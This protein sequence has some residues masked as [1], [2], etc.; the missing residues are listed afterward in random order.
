MSNIE[1]N[2]EANSRFL[3]ARQKQP[4]Q[5]K[6]QKTDNNNN[7]TTAGLYTFLFSLSPTQPIFLMI[8]AQVRRG[9]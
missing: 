1:S 9:T 8:I 7:T 4:H 5:Q 3:I 2:D 6:R